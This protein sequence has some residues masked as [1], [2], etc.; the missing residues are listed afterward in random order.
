M[1]TDFTNKVKNPILKSTE[2]RE[3]LADRYE[4]LELLGEGMSGSVY[5]AK[6][7]SLS[8]T[9]AVK[10]LHGHLLSHPNSLKRFEQEAEAVSRLSHPNIVNLYDFGVLPPGAPYIVM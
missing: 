7:N 9:V 1:D 4:V 3:M 2:I 5:K 10:V 8:R 6:H